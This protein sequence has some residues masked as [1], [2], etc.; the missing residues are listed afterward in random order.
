MLPEEWAILVGI[1]VPTYPCG[2]QIPE[3]LPQLPNGHPIL[4]HN[5][6]FALSSDFNISHLSEEETMP[7]AKGCSE[8]TSRVQKSNTYL[9][10]LPSCDAF[11]IVE[12]QLSLERSKLAVLVEPP[13]GVGYGYHL[14]YLSVRTVIGFLL[15]WHCSGSCRSSCD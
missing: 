3:N 1:V 12:I 10:Y 2:D 5:F 9:L 7:S 4:K 15:A 6:I 14:P 11:E 8:Y 13:G